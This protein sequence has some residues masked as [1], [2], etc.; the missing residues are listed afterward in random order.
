MPGR[1]RPLTHQQR[2]RK[3]R[4]N[5]VPVVSSWPGPADFRAAANPSGIEGSTDVRRSR[6]DLADNGPNGMSARKWCRQSSV[7]CVLRPRGPR[8][9]AWRLYPPRAS[10]RR[11]RISS[12]SQSST[13][14]SSMAASIK[15]GSLPMGRGIRQRALG[16][17]SAPLRRVAR[18]Y[19]V[20]LLVRRPGGTILGLRGQRSAC[21]QL[22][23]PW[24]YSTDSADRNKAASREWLL[25][26]DGRG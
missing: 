1:R 4:S 14:A 16:R 23:P 12:I 24:R 11:S 25:V 5:H 7:R 2:P 17:N 9:G 22:A 20:L 15:K 18:C 6:I 3:S 19:R 21:S 8:L 26:E 10:F 13:S